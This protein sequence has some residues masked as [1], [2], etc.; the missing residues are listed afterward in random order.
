MRNWF[1]KEFGKRA[2]KGVGTSAT[3]SIRRLGPQG[4]KACASIHAQSFPHPWST[5][6]FE[7]LLAARDV[8]AHAA[9][10]PASLRHWAAGPAGF[11][12]SRQAADEAEILT[13]AVAPGARRR[14]IGAALLANH[15]PALAAAG[16]RCLFLEV[17]A[18]NKAAIKLYQSFG[19]RQ[20]GERKAYYR[21]ADG[22]RAT[23]L[24]LR[25]DLA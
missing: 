20:V 17:E 13:L 19:F 8:I 6:E 16:V 1:R 7:S 2:G 4:G 14:G 15:L 10:R 5:E 11:V 21:A 24:V 22:G 9:M 23:A 3:P 12:L 25:R 18:D